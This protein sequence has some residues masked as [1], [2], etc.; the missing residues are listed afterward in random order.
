MAVSSN[1]INLNDEE[2][3]SEKKPE[4]YKQSLSSDQAYLTKIISKKFEPNAKVFVIVGGYGDLKRAL[5]NRG[6]QENHDLNSKIFN[7]K[8]T[9]KKVDLNF[10]ELMPHQIVNHFEKNTSITT[11]VGLARNIRNLIW[12]NNED[13]DNFYPRCYD[14]NDLA[15]FD[16]FIEDFKYTGVNLLFKKY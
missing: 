6:W 3:V 13:V 7:F 4:K 14:L 16:D 5:E 9:L 2:E 1:K 11:K 12:F 8:W 10:L 15:E